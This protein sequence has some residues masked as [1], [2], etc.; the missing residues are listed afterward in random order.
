MNQVEKKKEKKT[1][2]NLIQHHARTLLM[3]NK[4]YSNNV[5]KIGISDIAK[6]LKQIKRKINLTGGY[7]V[8]WK[9]DAL[10]S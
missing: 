3:E 9:Q 5:I 8:Y 7:F 1:E 2:T 4:Y 6:G 10:S